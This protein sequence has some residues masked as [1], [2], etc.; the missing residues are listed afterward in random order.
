MQDPIILRRDDILSPVEA[1]YWKDLLYRASKIGTEIEVATPS[2]VRRPVFE[3]AIRSALEPSGSFERL[4]PNGVLDVQTEHCGIEIRVIGRH[5]SFRALQKQYNQ[6]MQVITLNGGRVKSTCGLHF[7][8]LTPGLAEPVPEIIMA[9]LWNLVRRYAPELKYL[10]STGDKREALCRRRNHN[11]HLEMVR[12]SPATMTMKD[13]YEQLKKSKIVP[14]HQNFFNIQHLGFVESGSILPLH[15]EY[16]FPDATLSASA[17]TAFSFLFL[18]LLLKAVNLSQFGV[19]HVGKIKQ[20]R[21]K[22][23]ILNLLSNND[24]DL[25]TSDTSG[26]SDEVVSELR[27]GANELLELLQSL[28][29]RFNH[30]QAFE[31]LQ[32]LADQPISLMRCAGYDW[33]TIEQRLHQKVKLMDFDFEKVERRLMLGIELCEWTKQLS[34]QHWESH[35]A[36]ELL[37]SPGD[38]EKRIKKIQEFRELRWD[39][40]KGTMTFTS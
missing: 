35:V 30:N 32:A 26:V 37:L 6:I 9:N 25:A 13:I 1:Q 23:E 5:P 22:Q 20:W 7:H 3:D 18:A 4:G 36:K 27:N 11:S 40:Q 19:I 12:H 29:Q 17:V 14:E 21:R 8:L 34:Q 31:V 39:N 33:P 24:G 28:F 10:T 16:R 2:G 38:I 15:L